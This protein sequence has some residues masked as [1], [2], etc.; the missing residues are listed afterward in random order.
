MKQSYSVV[1]Y[2]SP[3]FEARKTYHLPSTTV[4]GHVEFSQF[5]N[6]RQFFQLGI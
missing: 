4:G 2:L 5:V 3:A 6:K 1:V